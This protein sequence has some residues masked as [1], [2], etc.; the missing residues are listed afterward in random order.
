MNNSNLVLQQA[1][2][3]RSSKNKLERSQ[4]LP[5]TIKAE[6]PAHNYSSQTLNSTEQAK[7]K[8]RQQLAQ[9]L[10]FNIVIFVN[11]AKVETAPRATTG[12]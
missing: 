11:L 4:T 12:L 1:V 10:N 6:G 3:E 8:L 9:V 5:V 7:E 2:R